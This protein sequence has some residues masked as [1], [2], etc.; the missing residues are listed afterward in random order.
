MVSSLM[1][2]RLAIEGGRPLTGSVRVSGSKN[3]ADYALVACLMTGEECVLEN[4]PEIDDVRVMAGILEAL[5][6]KVK[7]EGGGVWRVR[8]DRIERF[9]APNELVV[10][11]RASFLVMGPLLGRFAAL[12]AVL[13]AVTS[14]GRGR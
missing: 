12:L 10:N 3:G 4:V 14:W 11:Q 8:A 5:G 6:A 7:N 9:D 13:P 1:S 2:P